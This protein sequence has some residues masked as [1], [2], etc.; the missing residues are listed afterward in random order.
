MS[1]VVSERPA[2]EGGTPV[3]ETKLTVFASAISEEA[4]HEVEAV[5]RSGWLATGPRV[6][7]FETQFARYVG[8]EHAVAVTSGTQALELALAGLGVGE[9]DEVITTPLT[10]VAT[11]HAILNRGATPVLVDIDARNW[12][13]DPAL[14]EAAITARTRCVLPVHFAGRPSEMGPL[15]GIANRHGLPLLSDCAHAIET[16][17]EGRNVGGYG[18]ANAYSFHPCKSVTTGEGGMVATNDAALA[19]RVRR[20]RFHGL[21]PAVP[22]SGWLRDVTGPGCKANMSDLQAALGLHQLRTV[23]ERHARRCVL[24]ERYR[25]ALQNSEAVELPAPVPSS[26]RHG[27]HLFNVLLV[28]ERLRIDRRVLI[29]AMAAEHVEVAIH[30]RPLHCLTYLQDRLGVHEESCPVATQV[31]R[32]ILSLPLHDAMSEADVASVVT[33]LGRVIGYYGC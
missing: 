22:G 4:I 15:I 18:V 1:N 23:E 9:G 17:Y 8:V 7:A 30:Y 29:E 20:R 3:R 19:E 6:A 10:F 11:A 13:L 25:E 5:L 31:A 24:A 32:R 2:R 16:G 14:L 26:Q 12:T 21:V 33:A 28:P 27:W